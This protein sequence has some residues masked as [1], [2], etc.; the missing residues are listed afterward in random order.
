MNSLEIWGST[1]TTIT[2]RDGYDGVGGPNLLTFELG[3]VTEALDHIARFKLDRKRMVSN[4][5]PVI[6]ESDLITMRD[7]MRRGALMS[8]QSFPDA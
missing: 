1:P 3:E 2:V 4:G 8:G 5:S 7:T 6:S